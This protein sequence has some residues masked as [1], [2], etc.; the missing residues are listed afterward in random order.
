LRWTCLVGADEV[1]EAERVGLVGLHRRGGD[2]V[3][4]LEARGGVEGA[5]E[6]LKW[7]RY[8][9]T[10]NLCQAQSITPSARRGPTRPGPLTSVTPRSRAL[11]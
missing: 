5:L 9:G 7:Q 6:G 4:R 1:A 11:K 3:R 2:A 8:G 10:N